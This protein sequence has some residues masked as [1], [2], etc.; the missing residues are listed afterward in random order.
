MMKNN[1]ESSG[2]WH[3]GTKYEEMKPTAYKKEHSSRG[4]KKKATGEVP[5][6]EL[7]SAT[8]SGRLG[9]FHSWLQCFWCTQQTHTVVRLVLKK[10][11]QHPNSY[12]KATAVE[13][14]ILVIKLIF[15]I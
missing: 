4:K 15:P 9:S 1:K 12:F 14:A 8:A 5:E 10:C 3:L 6:R 2:P 11:D 7:H 13:S